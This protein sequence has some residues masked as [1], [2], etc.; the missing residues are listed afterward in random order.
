MSNHRG[1]IYLEYVH[2]RYQSLMNAMLFCVEVHQ[3]IDIY[4]NLYRQSLLSILNLKLT[5]LNFSNV[6]FPSSLVIPT[7]MFKLSRIDRI[8]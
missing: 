8:V 3:C 1:E 6:S 2:F 5:I 4:I 7:I